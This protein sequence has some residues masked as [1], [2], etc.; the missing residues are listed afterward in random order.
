[1]YF[2]CVL[3]FGSAQF[4]MVDLSLVLTCLSRLIRADFLSFQKKTNKSKS[5]L[6]RAADFII[7]YNARCGDRTRHRTCL[8]NSVGSGHGSCVHH[9]TRITD[10]WA[11]CS[12]CL[13]YNML[14]KLLCLVTWKWDLI[15][16]M[17]GGGSRMIIVYGFLENFLILS[18]QSLITI[19]YDKKFYSQLATLRE[20]AGFY[21]FYLFDCVS[22]IEDSNWASSTIIIASCLK[23]FYN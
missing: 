4:L 11:L 2:G 1:M 19:T 3:N 7:G 15:S 12:Y 21:V 8:I 5:C 13:Y 10:I 6:N 18:T 17:R 16:S 22:S 9:S 14:N 20:K 23:R